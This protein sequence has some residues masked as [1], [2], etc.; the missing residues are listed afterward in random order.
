MINQD[1]I[2]FQ[3]KS[4]EHPERVINTEVNQ[5]LDFDISQENKDVLIQSGYE[6]ALKHIEEHLLD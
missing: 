1:P 2:V 4:G 5:G 3:I 6:C